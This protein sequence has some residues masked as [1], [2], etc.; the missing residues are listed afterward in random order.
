MVF[1]VRRYKRTAVSKA[2]ILSALGDA[3]ALSAMATDFLNSRRESKHRQ[4]PPPE[5]GGLFLT[6]SKEVSK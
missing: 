5:G 6:S 3:L 4:L 2:V 1:L